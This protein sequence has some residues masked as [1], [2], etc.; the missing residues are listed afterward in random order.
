MKILIAT[1]IFGDDIKL[2][3][4]QSMIQTMAYLIR[5]G[6]EFDVMHEARNLIHQARNRMAHYAINN[7]FDKLM[8]IDADISWRISDLD[9]LIKS[10][11]KIVGG[12]YPLKTFPIRL[13]FVPMQGIYGSA[14]TFDVNEYMHKYADEEG[15]VEVHMIPTGFLMI[16]IS[17]F[18]DLDPI[19][20]QYNHRDPMRKEL[21]FEKMYF[22]FKIGEDGFLLTEDWGFCDLVRKLGYKIYWQT[23]AI[24]DH[25]GSHTYSAITPLDKSY[26][27][28]DVTTKTTDNF[29]TNPE[30]LQKVIKKSVLNPF[31]KW[32]S[33][34]QCFCGSGKKFKKCHQHTLGQYCS[35]EEAEALRP[36]FEKTLAYVQGLRAQG[37]G[38]KLAEPAL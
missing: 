19:V 34:L 32:P 24:V 37:V 7:G 15:A 14:T 11:H 10:N 36:D 9:A 23:K 3:Y 31:R 8:F 22:P 1:P 38:Y 28:L 16:D 35:K 26:K 12:T 25:V 18:K 13:N 21:E 5:N 30:D 20:E 27:R 6:I 33:N 2:K 17:V 4:H 29:E